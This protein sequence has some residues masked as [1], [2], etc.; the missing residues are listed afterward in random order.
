M[1]MVCNKGIFIVTDLPGLRMQTLRWQ[2]WTEFSWWNNVYND[3]FSV[4]THLERGFAIE[5]TYA[6]W[7]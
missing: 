6:Q 2:D 1:I 4:G 5:Y 7:L 3:K